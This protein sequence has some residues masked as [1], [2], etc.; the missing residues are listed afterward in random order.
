MG[1]FSKLFS[2]EG[3]EPNESEG[4]DAQAAQPGSEGGVKKTDESGPGG[5]PQKDAR[6]A[7][8]AERVDPL[9]PSA[10]SDKRF[11]RTEAGMGGQQPAPGQKRAVPPLEAPE[12]AGK[13]A[14]KV[15]Q[16]KRD[17]APKGAAAPAPVGG[18]APQPMAAG[19]VPA[20]P[21]A[22]PAADV[23]QPP[24]ARRGIAGPKPNEGPITQT[25]AI[26]SPIP[27]L[28]NANDSGSLQI[29]A[30]VDAAMARITDVSGHIPHPANE[31]RDASDHKAVADTFADIAKVHAQP[32]RELMFQ[33]SVGRTP[34]QW[35]SACRPV[36]RPLFDAATQIGMLELVGGLGAFDA[37]LER[38]AAEPNAFVSDG[39]ADA[40]KAAYERLR[41]QMPDAFMPPD[42]ADN[43][44]MILLEA[45]LLQVP[46]MHRRTLA[47]LYAAGLSTLSQLASA[48][49]EEIAVV[50]GVDRKLAEAVVV[51][52]QRFEQERSRV[53]P[54]ALRAQLQERLK[55]IIERLSKLQD[56]FEAAEEGDSPARKRTSRRDRE[57]AVLE[58]DVIFAEAGDVD[59]IE[60][61]KRC[62]VR[63]KIE[64]I[65]SY[66]ERLQA[67][68]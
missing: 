31:Q 12:A 23:S 55:S 19:A 52:V 48:N 56:E 61:L 43:R 46:D 63:G 1:L 53:D 9:P 64:R 8:A 36:L 29:D 50:A 57:A 20:A 24:A 41:K 32:L 16:G 49:A 60:E 21:A 58:L 25:K 18:R 35:A 34:R 65:T 54:T 40:M 51:H 2:R 42:R 14:K 26:G 22:P 13:A 27:P 39:A 62:P 3:E 45:L 33:I 10:A 67:T 47:K 68:A 5:G 7:A 30:A 15:E 17:P 59:L 44:R 11:A 6:R 38:A 66:L 4:Q 37:A 28:P